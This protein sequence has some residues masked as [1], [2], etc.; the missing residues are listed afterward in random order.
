MTR[1]TRRHLSHKKK[2]S[3]RSTKCFERQG[4][5]SEESDVLYVSSLFSPLKCKRK[6]LCFVVFGVLDEKRQQSLKK[7]ESLG[8]RER[9]AEQ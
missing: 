1:K 5:G 4:E 8:K 7:K 9:V 6:C 2:E 3:F